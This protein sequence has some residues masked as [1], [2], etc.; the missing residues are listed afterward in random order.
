MD[1][2]P[3]NFWSRFNLWLRAEGRHAMF[4]VIAMAIAAVAIWGGED[5]AM[6]IAGLT[7]IAGLLVFYRR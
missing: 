5:S 3:R 4:A 7:W 6:A 2:D 1:D